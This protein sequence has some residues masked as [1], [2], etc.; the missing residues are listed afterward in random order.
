MRIASLLPSATEIVHALG[1]A[2]E[3][4]GVTFECDFPPD[5]RVGRTILVGGLDSHGPDGR[6]LDAGE[7][8]ALV[9]AKVA[10]GEDLYRLDEDAFR[11]AAPDVVLTQDLCRV[12]ALP[13]GE[14]DAALDR[15]GCTANV[16][17]L[18]PHTLEEI[19]ATVVAV[20]EA[21]GTVDRAVALVESLRVRVAEVAGRVAGRAEP[22]V[23][24]LEWPDPPFVAG[25]WVPELVAAAGGRPVLSRPGARSVP[26]TWPEVAATGATVVVVAS[27]GFD[28]AGTTAHALDVLDHLPVGADVWAVD[29]N[30]VMVRPGPRV[31]DGIE[32]LA[33]ILHGGDVDP[34]LAARVR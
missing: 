3:L 34:A 29:A 11:V 25:H 30:A 31:V 20:G 27:C 8:D 21:T 17:T 2:E 32:L 9:R 19:F 15:L 23:F 14:V 7:I 26:T 13:S 16:V 28:V 33:A 22:A 24:V 4:V 12:C 10:A 18:D 1:L 5:P 6:A